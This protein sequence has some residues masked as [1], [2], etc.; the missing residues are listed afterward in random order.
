MMYLKNIYDGWTVVYKEKDGE[1][2]AFTY[3]LFEDA[4]QAK[5]MI[6]DSNGGELIDEKG[7]YAGILELE[8]CHL[9]NGKII[10]SKENV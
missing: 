2:K 10:E 3:T 5:Q 7:N 6:D 8:W 9:I 1:V 4:E